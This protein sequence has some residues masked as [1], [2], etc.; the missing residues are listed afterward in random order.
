MSVI[1]QD[2][3]LSSFRKAGGR[4]RSRIS[5]SFRERLILG[6]LTV[7]SIFPAWCV[8]GYDTWALMTF[9]FVSLIGFL[10]LFVPVAQEGI[11]VST[12][13]R[14][15]FRF[16]VFWIGLLFLSYIVWQGV[17]PAWVYVKGDYG[18]WAVKIPHIK[19]LPSGM[20]SPFFQSNA[21]KVLFQMASGFFI[22]CMV[23]VGLQ[24]RKSIRYVFW[25]IAINGLF[26]AIFAV[27][28]KH[29]GIKAVYGMIQSPSYEFL[30]TFFYR[31]HGVAYLYLVLSV[32]LGLAW[33]YLGRSKEEMK[34]SGPH[35]ICLFMSLF[36]LGAI[37]L[38]FSRTGVIAIVVI[39]LFFSLGIAIRFFRGGSWNARIVRLLLIV[40]ALG[41]ATAVTLDSRDEK[42]WQSRLDLLF[43]D[44][45][46]Y[47]SNR[48]VLLMEAT[49]EMFKDNYLF[50]TGAG[51]F[52]YRFPPY[53]EKYPSLDRLSAE[54]KLK[55]Y[56]RHAHTDLF[57]FLAEYGVLGC[58]LI[59][60]GFFYFG[61]KALSR[62]RDM[63]GLV[64]MGYVGL[65]MFLLHSIYDF[66][67]QNP[68]LLILFV[69]VMI[70]TVRFHVLS[71]KNKLIT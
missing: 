53:K 7:L 61:Y 58:S 2:S 57:Q 20:D 6:P 24:S 41:I 3:L 48:R 63:N 18:W 40:L 15:L 71:G 12:T 23:W 59:L 35:Y 52:R 14:S 69:L 13:I 67:F 55:A 39:G 26:F 60:M 46:N 68:A 45:M 56:Y 64:Y 36:L 19:W 65:G 27:L 17:N 4:S 34:E 11:Q 9:F 50:G 62:I 38:S 29:L 49:W 47:E 31:N 8:G 42:K 1:P 43:S 51:S 33:Y 10:L 37:G 21:F 25:V 30:G 28:Q 22:I 70:L 32:A 54:S 44:L 5:I 16:P 66:V